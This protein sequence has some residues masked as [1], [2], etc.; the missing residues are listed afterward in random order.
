LGGGW[1][2]GGGGWGVGGGGVVWSGRHSDYD[3]ERAKRK[4][5]LAKG[6]SEKKCDKKVVDRGREKVENLM[7]LMEG[8]TTKENFN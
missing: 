8:V 7:H 2:G 4:R 6:G 1:G 3:N 5:V